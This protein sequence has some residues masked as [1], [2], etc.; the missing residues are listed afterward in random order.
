MGSGGCVIDACRCKCRQGH[1]SDGL[2]NA[3]RSIL[4]A[5]WILLARLL[6][7]VTGCGLCIEAWTWHMGPE[8]FEESEGLRNRWSVSQSGQSAGGSNKGNMGR[9]AQHRQRI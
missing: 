6:E 7:S 9:L 1:G 2:A 4:W 8:A 3:I 5:S